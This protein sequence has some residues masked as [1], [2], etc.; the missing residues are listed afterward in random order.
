MDL[1]ENVQFPVT[2]SSL[3]QYASLRDQLENQERKLALSFPSTQDSSSTEKLAKDI[4]QSM[5][6]KEN[7]CLYGGTGELL[8]LEPGYH[9]GRAIETINGSVV[10][11]IVRKAPKGALL[12]CHLDAML[13]PNTM[14]NLA[15]NAHNMCIR[16]DAPLSTPES[17]TRV[18]PELSILSRKEI[19]TLD[20]TDVFNHSYTAGKWMLYSTFL[21]RFPGGNCAAEQWISSKIILS[22]GDVYHS[23]Q[24]VNG[25][26]ALF[27]SV[28]SS[29]H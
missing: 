24:T 26:V 10:M 9:Y 6:E 3:E 18:L 13:P 25:L 21:E 23:Y 20:N 5:K 12:H 11:Q 4:L 28:Y 29:I 27:I 8:K 15:K 14:F 22:L 19:K 2:Y 7:Q 1:L 16:T 17:F